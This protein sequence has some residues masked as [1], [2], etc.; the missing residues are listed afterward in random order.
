MSELRRFTN[1][2]YSGAL[3]SLASNINPAS[4]LELTQGK[5]IRSEKILAGRGGITYAELPAIGP[6]IVKHY[7]RGGLMGRLIQHR[8]IYSAVCRAEQELL[9]LERVRALGVCAPEPV[10]FVRKGS[11]LYQNWLITR[12]IQHRA[13]L[14][15][16]AASEEEFVDQIAA[17]L[18]AQ[19]QILVENGIFHVDLHPGNVLVGDKHKVSILDFD[20][21]RDFRGPLRALRDQY[22]FRWRRAVLKHCLPDVLNEAV[23][24]GLRKLHG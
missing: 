19:I 24:L 20:K 9:M 6:V 3:T 4:L 13:S 12:E 16:L 21:A 11:L 18:V 1:H 17:E 10:G 22:I 23:C 7:T 14:A 8:Y 15:E 2:R 5:G